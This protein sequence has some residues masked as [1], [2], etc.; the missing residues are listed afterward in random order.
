MNS[1]GHR[2]IVS[3][4]VSLFMIVSTS[5][6]G[7]LSDPFWDLLHKTDSKIE[8][9]RSD[10]SITKAEISD[11]ELKAYYRKH[12][13]F[14]DVL[15]LKMEIAARTISVQGGQIPSGSSTT[16]ELIEEMY[17]SSG[18]CRGLFMK[19]EQT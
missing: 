2:F 13:D 6:Y 12:S 3:F 17:G 11:E 4:L 15:L 8:K 10:F 18:K 7:A 5:A 14:A 9:L 16:F 1:N 19:E